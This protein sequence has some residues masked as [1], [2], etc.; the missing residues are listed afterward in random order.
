MKASGPQL[1]RKKKR[2][3][4]IFQ[5]EGLHLEDNMVF[6]KRTDYLDV[7]FDLDKGTYEPYTKPNNVIKYIDVRSNHPRNIIKHIPEIVQN[8]LSNISSS[9]EIFDRAKPCY[10]DA[11]RRA[12]YIEGLEFKPRIEEPR[13]KNEDVR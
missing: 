8:R 1:E 9:K 7:I 2:I 10:Q 4:K 5:E 11:L 13:E 12:G 6:S 3:V